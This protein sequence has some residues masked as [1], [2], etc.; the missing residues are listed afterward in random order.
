[1]VSEAARVSSGGVHTTRQ[2]GGI[3]VFGNQRRLDD[4]LS[5]GLKHALDELARAWIALR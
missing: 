2:H 3:A 4:W 1:M 5:G